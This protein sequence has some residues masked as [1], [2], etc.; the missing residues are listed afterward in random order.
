[1]ATAKE[2]G[3]AAGCRVPL[4]LLNNPLCLV[5]RAVLWRAAVSLP[6]KAAIIKPPFFAREMSETVNQNI[7]VLFFKSVDFKFLIEI[8]VWR[9]KNN[10]LKRLSPPPPPCT[11]FSRSTLA[12]AALL[13][14][15]IKRGKFGLV[16]VDGM[17]WA[18]RISCHTQNIREA[19]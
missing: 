17:A 19:L 3:I 6:K 11:L 8:H 14:F 2:G 16:V 18:D 9:L 13:S 1:M 5:D 12:A 4:P 15:T 10:R 7:S